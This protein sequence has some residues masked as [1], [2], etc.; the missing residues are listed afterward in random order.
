[1]STSSV[2]A[3]QVYTWEPS[4]QAIAERYGLRPSDILRFDLNTSVAAPA[5]VAEALAGPFDPPLNEYPDSLYADLA[6]AA[7]DYVGADRDEILVGAGADEVLD[8]IAKTFIPAGGRAIVPIPTYSMY[9]VLTNQR[10][11]HIEA[12]PR[13]PAG[14]GFGADIEAILARLDGAD[15]VWLCAPNNPTG[16]PEPLDRIIRILD[17]AAELGTRAPTVVVDEAYFEFTRQTSVPLRSTYPHLVTVRTLS[18]AFALPGMRVG[19]A[20]AQRPTIERLERNRPPGS[21]STVSA[22]VGTWA[23]R[24]PELA[25]AMVERVGPEREWLRAQLDA[26]GWTTH[27]SVANFVLARVGAP[28]DT[29]VATDWL[30]RHG[31]VSR[32]F[33]PANPLR[34]HLR[35]TVRTRED[36]ERLVSAVREWQERRTP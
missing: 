20:V 35:F 23:L 17:A 13:R 5:F 16:S 8:I 18:K 7:A 32:T 15:V 11:G 36:D 25:A 24:R 21:V 12:V 4:N 9:G 27:P 6:Q 34:G 22:A 33:G 28:D 1:M 14:E 26:L 19:Y 2:W 30:L 29:D 10:A 3:S 31:I